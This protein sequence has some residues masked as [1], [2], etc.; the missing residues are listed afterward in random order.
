MGPGGVEDPLNA[1]LAVSP[2][3]G[4][5]LPGPRVLGFLGCAC[6]VRRTAFISAGGYDE[7]LG[8]RGEEEMLAMDLAAAGWTAAFV[9]TV[10]ARQFPSP[11]RNVAARQAVQRRNPVLVAWMRRPLSRAPAATADI[12]RRAPADPVARRAL[13][14][15]LPRLLPGL[16]PR[17][18]RALAARR[19]LPAATEA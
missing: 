11:S 14:G 19:R 10:V 13:A 16:L 5:G 7:L 6:V 18:P 15:L 2:L 3:P 4:D 17:L 9:D 12:V 8:V 1:M